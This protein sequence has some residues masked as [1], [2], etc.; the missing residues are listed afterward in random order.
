MAR[1]PPA[2]TY[3]GTARNLARLAACLRAGDL[4]AVPTETVYGLAAHALDARACARIFRAKGR[5]ASDPLI[6]HLHSVRQL[7]LVC[8][9]NAAAHRL[10]RAFWPGPLTLV[11]PKTPAVPAIVTS[12]RDSVAVRVPRHPLFRRLL[13]LAG[14]PLAAPSANPFGYISPTTAEHVRQGLGGKIRHILDGG[15]ASIGLESTIV[16]LRDPS[17]PAVLRPGAITAE[18]IA[19]VLGR[20]VAAPQPAAAQPGAQVAPGLL[21]RHYSPR[22]PLV[23]HKKVPAALRGR[24]PANEAFLLQRQP[25]GAASAAHVFWLDA[26]GDLPGVARRLFA[27]L[28]RLDAQGFVRIHA[29]LAP[30]R[31]LGRA[32][33]D[34]LRRA[35]AR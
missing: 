30:D 34:R 12:G 29:E 17:R 16:D 3:R 11:L 27:M 35:A 31:G 9:P 20:R 8:L 33:N 19:R 10:A 23:L 24:A 15:P 25:R 7:G 6:V 4:V 1:T 18:Q 32:I 28:R 26:T 22:T 2:R 21:A 13:R 14:V 5:P